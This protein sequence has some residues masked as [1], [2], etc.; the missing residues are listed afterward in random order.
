MRVRAACL[1]AQGAQLAAE[2][3]DGRAGARADRGQERC[4]RR[5]EIAGLR[6]QAGEIDGLVSGRMRIGM[7]LCA[8][9]T[10]QQCSRQQ[11]AKRQLATRPVHERESTICPWQLD[12]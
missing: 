3:D 2:C 4:E 6:V 5:T 9:L 1:R 12:R 7:R 8:K 10:E 11:E